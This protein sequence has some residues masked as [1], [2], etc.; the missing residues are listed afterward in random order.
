MDEWIDTFMDT[1]T[2]HSSSAVKEGLLPGVTTQTKPQD[3]KL[4]EGRQTPHFL[5]KVKLTVKNGDCAGLGQ[6]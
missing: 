6:G 2:T 4:S 1:D 3:T 5:K